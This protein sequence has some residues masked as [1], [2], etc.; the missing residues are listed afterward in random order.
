MLDES[1]TE[2]AEK[3]KTTEGRRGEKREQMTRGSLLSAIHMCVCMYLYIH[4][5]YIVN[6]HILSNA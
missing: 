2:S 3:I 1:R 5:K 4:V 6:M